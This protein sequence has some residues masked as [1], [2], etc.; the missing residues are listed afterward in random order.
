M[1]ELI[2]PALLTDP[3]LPFLP[4][5]PSR[6]KGSSNSNVGEFDIVGGGRSEVPRRIPA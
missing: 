3:A 1:F 5:R 6:D 2:V 4:A